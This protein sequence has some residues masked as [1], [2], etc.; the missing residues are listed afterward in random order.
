MHAFSEEENVIA[1]KP[2]P[3]KA[4]H[5]DIPVGVPIEKTESA[6]MANSFA[7]EESKGYSSA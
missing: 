3:E 2:S 4:W 5:K 7:E 6:I 1:W